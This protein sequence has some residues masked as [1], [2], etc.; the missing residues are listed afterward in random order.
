MEMPTSATDTPTVIEIKSIKDRATFLGENFPDN[1]IL[2]PGEVFVKT[3]EIKNIGS[4]QWSTGYQLIA[5]SSPS[6]DSLGSP[7]MINFPKETAP[8]ESVQLSV[9][10]TAPV[11]T[12]SYTLFWIIKNETGEVVSVDGDRLWVK[13]QVCETKQACNQAVGGGASTNKSGVTITITNFFYNTQITTVNY[14]ISIAGLQDWRALREYHSWP[15]APKLLLDQKSAPF[16]EGGSDFSSGDGCAYMV[17]QANATEIEQAQQVSLVIDSLRMGIPP[18]DP[19]IACETARKTLLT[20]YPG[21][22]F[23]C[24]FSMAGYYTDL[25]PPSGMSW[26]DADSLINATIEGAIYGPWT[27]ILKIKN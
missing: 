24:N 26:A 6:G 16:Q 5:V 11:K 10:L 19:N 4:T 23:Q 21:L 8:G 15:A 27:L 7:A 3:W 14:C 2:I 18:G 17:Y 22:N 13:I 20:Q 25:Q 12:G 9:S 1:S